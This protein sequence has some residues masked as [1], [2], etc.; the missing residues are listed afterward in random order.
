M[1]PYKEGGAPAQS[2]SAGNG[3][4]DYRLVFSRSLVTYPEE[5]TTPLNVWLSKEESRAPD[6]AE[7]IKAEIKAAVAVPL[8]ECARKAAA[9]EEWRRIVKRATTLK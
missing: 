6:H 1:D 4:S 8:H 5:T 2:G 3:M 7:E 9:R